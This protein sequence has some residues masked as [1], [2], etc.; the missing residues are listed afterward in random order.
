MSKIAHP[1]GS[2]SQATPRLENEKEL[3]SMIMDMETKHG[4]IS[5]LGMPMLGILSVRGVL[6]RIIST[7]KSKCLPPSLS[8]SVCV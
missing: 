5:V 3:T 6:L 2:R 8:L 1:E 4:K 7:S